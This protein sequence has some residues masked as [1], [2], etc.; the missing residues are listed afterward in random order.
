[1]L[2]G[3]KSVVL[4]SSGSLAKP[5]GLNFPLVGISFGCFGLYDEM[6]HGVKGY[7]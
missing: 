2:S 3:Q 5:L 7:C 4:L 6:P 1:M